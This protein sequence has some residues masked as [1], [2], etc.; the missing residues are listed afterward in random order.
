[1]RGLR[2]LGFCLALAALAACG[3]KGEPMTPEAGTHDAGRDGLVP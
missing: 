3:I 2:L 1:V